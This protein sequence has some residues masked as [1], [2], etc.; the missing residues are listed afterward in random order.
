M[1]GMREN[2]A[3]VEV[4]DIAPPAW[5]VVRSAA[6]S[7]AAPPSAELMAESNTRMDEK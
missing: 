5:P 7:D 6:R 4:S 3:A 1:F 2:S